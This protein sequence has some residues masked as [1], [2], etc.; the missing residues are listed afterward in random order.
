MSSNAI[1][2][3]FWRPEEHKVWVRRQPKFGWGWTIN[4]AEISR[5]LRG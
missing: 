3:E 4:F 5:R 1:K 2:R